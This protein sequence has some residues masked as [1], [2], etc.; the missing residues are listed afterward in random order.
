MAG[1]SWDTLYI[2]VGKVK[3]YQ[4]V[5]KLFNSVNSKFFGEYFVNKAETKRMV[6]RKVV[7]LVVINHPL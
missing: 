1:K 4:L 3:K 2:T 5:K 6:G 7:A